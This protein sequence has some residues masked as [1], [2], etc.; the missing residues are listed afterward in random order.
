ML[1][2]AQFF[3]AMGLVFVSLLLSSIWTMTVRY[4]ELYNKKDHILLRIAVGCGTVI[5]T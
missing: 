1:R 5:C 3:S 4:Y 2:L